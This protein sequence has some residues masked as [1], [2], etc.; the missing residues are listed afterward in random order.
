MR[1]LSILLFSFS[2][3]GSTQTDLGLWLGAKVRVYDQGKFKVDIENQYRFDNMV[4]HMES[5]FISPSIEY[6]LHEH[7]DI[8]Y[9]YR[10]I[11]SSD[12]SDP[13]SYFAHRSGVDV[14]FRK[15]GRLL[16][17]NDRLDLNFRIRA[18]TEYSGRDGYDSYLRFSPGIAYNIKGNKLTPSI[19]AE[20]FYHFRDQVIY[21]FDEVKTISAFNK[22]RIKGGV[23]YP[24]TEKIDL[25]ANMIFQHRFPISK[26][27]VIPEL[28]FRYQL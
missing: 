28:T 18:T 4:R 8:S 19:S 1:I 24:I 23:R 7:V 2:F 5:A 17:K 21:T 12:G 25:D 22:I 6:R 27:E 15:L 11:L 10:C 9:A 14:Q 13:V 16:F 26:K 20:L 3:W